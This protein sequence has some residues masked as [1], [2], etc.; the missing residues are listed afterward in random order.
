MYAQ[1]ITP[2]Y[3]LVFDHDGTSYNVNNNSE[4]SQV[5]SCGVS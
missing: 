2:G 5:A 4:G 1:V 3:R